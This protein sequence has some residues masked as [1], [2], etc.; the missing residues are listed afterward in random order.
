M[1]IGYCF[2]GSFCT[3]SKSI[4]VMEELAKQGHTIIPIFS[5]NVRDLDNRFWRAEE[6]RKRVREITDEGIVDN[7]VLAEPLGP[8]VKCDVMCVSPCTSNTLSKLRYGI[9]DTPVTM[10]VKAHLRIERPVVIA[11][12]TNDGLGACNEVLGEM[13]NRKHYYFAPLY[14]DD[15]VKKPRSLV[16]D[17]SQLIPTIE[18]AVKGKQYQPILTQKQK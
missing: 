7:I 8:V 5:Y 11:L 6:F 13:R 14:Q 4:A 3:L 16:T 2:T 12:C 9:T 18:C 15:L 17:F 10:A 1:L